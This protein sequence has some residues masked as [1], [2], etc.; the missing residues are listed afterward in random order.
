VTSRCRASRGG[1]SGEHAALYREASRHRVPT[2]AGAEFASPEYTRMAIAFDE[3][4]L[5]LGAPDLHQTFPRSLSRRGADACRATTPRSRV[6]RSSRASWPPSRG[7]SAHRDYTRRKPHA[8]RG[9]A[10]HDRFPGCPDGARYYDL[11]YIAARLVRRL[12]EEQVEELLPS[13]GLKGASASLV[14]RDDARESGDGS[15]RWRCSGT[16]RR[17]GR[18]ASRPRTAANTVYIQYISDTELRARE[19][20]AIRAVRRSGRC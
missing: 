19:S 8:A 15:T 7:C 17:S 16:S 5:T 20:A 13:S 6:C 9:K 2:D 12:H 18:S 1:L 4:K 10:V 3:E 11:A 14:K